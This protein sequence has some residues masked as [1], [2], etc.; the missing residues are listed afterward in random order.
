M[1]VVKRERSAEPDA[2]SYGRLSERLSDTAKDFS[3]VAGGPLYQLLLRTRLV[4][5]PL[6]RVG[7]RVVVITTIAWLPLLVLTT[8]SGRLTSGAQIPFLYDFGA[9]ARF[10]IALPLLIIAELTVHRGMRELLLQFLNRQIIKPAALPKFEACIASSLRL[11]NSILAEVGLL[12]IIIL[13][14]RSWAR[15]VV[16]IPLDT[17]YTATAGGNRAIT[18]AGY[19]Y[20]FVSL[21]IVQFIALRW[22]FRLFIWARLLW[23]ISRL[24]LNLVPSHP[25]GRCG[26]GFLGQTVFA[27]AAFLMAHSVLLSGFIANRIVYQGIKLPDHGI[28]IAVVA[29]FLFLIALGPLFAFTPRLIRQRQA[30]VYSYGSL[31]SEYV[32]GFDRKWIQGERPPDEPLVGSA[33]IQ[34]L[35]DLA[36]SFAVV[37]HVVPFPFGREALISLVV[38]IALPILPLLLTMFSFKEL[39]ERLLKVLL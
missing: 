3:L 28:E 9:Q 33:D 18:F 32:I 14:E 34:S 1:D 6:D 12:I 30:A 8:L 5:P 23:K 35:A 25:D 15:S 19:W 27:L 39:V 31:A 26:L 2:L 11:R 21:P 38:M 37:Q 13:A 4:R 20:V 7:W 24:D 16:A 17:W 10:L 36:N 29:L 22:Y